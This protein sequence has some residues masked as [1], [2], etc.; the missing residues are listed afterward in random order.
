MT[1][2]GIRT[3]LVDEHEPAARLSMQRLAEKRSR[4]VLSKDDHEMLKGSSTAQLLYP[5]RTSKKSS[6]LPMTNVVPVNTQTAGLAEISKVRL[7]T[8]PLAIRG[9]SLLPAICYPLQARLPW[10]PARPRAHT[11]T[12]NSSRRASIYDLSESTTVGRGRGSH[13]VKSNEVSMSLDV[14]VFQW[15]YRHDRPTKPALPQYSTGAK[16][17]DRHGNAPRQVPVAVFGEGWI[18]NTGNLDIDY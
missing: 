9:L 10:T 4:L 6:L 14:Q 15:E 11:T 5:T 12:R 2:E 17:R 3:V 1:N 7:D 18:K 13:R 16:C 8:A